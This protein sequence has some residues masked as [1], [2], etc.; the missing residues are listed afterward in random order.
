MR[1]RAAVAR[2]T[3]LDPEILIFDEPSAGLDPL[4]LRNSMS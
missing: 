2:A 1:K 4:S 3:A